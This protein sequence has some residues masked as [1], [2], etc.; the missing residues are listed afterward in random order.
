MPTTVLWI[1]IAVVSAI[2]ALRFWS[3]KG[4]PIRFSLFTAILL[5]T[6]VGLTIVV[7][8]LWRE[9]GP[10]RVEVRQMRAQLGK[11]TI[12]DAEALRQRT[13]EESRAKADSFSRLIAQFQTAE[14]AGEQS[15]AS[16]RQM[17]LG[18]R[19]VEVMNEILG[20]VAGKVFL[21]SGQPVDLTIFRERSE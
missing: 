8:V 1:V 18:R 6:I 7:V 5:T 15:Y 13:V 10:L 2:V 3:R 14:R 17:A 11:L 9:V 20:K 21:D 19:Y 4:R 16:A 12:D